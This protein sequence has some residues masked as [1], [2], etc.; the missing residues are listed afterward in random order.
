M[1]L[2]AL[3]FIWSLADFAGCSQG[4]VDNAGHAFA[5]AAPAVNDALIVAQVEGSFITIDADSA[6]HVAVS[7]HDGVVKLSGRVK[8]DSI[9]DRFV[10][11]AR[12][13]QAV[14]TVDATLSID[15][16]LP[17]AKDQAADFALAVAV[18]ASIA[19]QSG[20]NALSVHVDAHGGTVT[21]TGTVPTRAIHATVAD[22]AK[23]TSGVKKVI[24]K[25]KVGP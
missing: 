15:P 17:S 19:G 1:K 20:L 11:A 8:S 13:T 3:I 18:Q 7:S 22:T 23:H 21:L 14:K 5:S 2:L 12:K 6:L 16:H 4:Q 24:D 9:R 25:L 10:A